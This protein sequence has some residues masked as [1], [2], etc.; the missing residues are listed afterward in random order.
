MTAS[1][2]PPA[3]SKGIAPP[4]S[5]EQTSDWWECGSLCRSSHLPCPPHVDPPPE[6]PQAPPS[7]LPPP[8][9]L[10]ATSAEKFWAKSW[11]LAAGSQRLRARRTKGSQRKAVSAQ[12]GLRPLCAPAASGRPRLILLQL[13]RELSAAHCGGPEK[14]LRLL[15][16][17]WTNL[18]A[19]H[20]RTRRG[21]R[22]QSAP[23]RGGRLPERCWGVVGARGGAGWTGLR[24]RRAGATSLCGTRVSLLSLVRTGP[25]GSPE[26]GRS[27]SAAPVSLDVGFECRPPW[28]PVL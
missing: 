3:C 6:R 25:W 14:P 16:G 1:W 7:R 13:V 27:S 22:R 10:Q 8:A 5:S 15:P 21:P 28:S 12:L 24:F 11:E 9:N 26:L 23:V 4:P 20:W 17:L 19:R 18:R 2:N